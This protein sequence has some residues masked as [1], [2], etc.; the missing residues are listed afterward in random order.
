M[1]GRIILNRFHPA[2]TEEFLL[3]HPHA[4]GKQQNLSG[5]LVEVSVSAGVLPHLCYG[6]YAHEHVIEPYGV[7]LRTVTGKG[8]VA[9]PV[10]LVHDIVGVVSDALVNQPAQLLV[11]LLEDSAHRLDHRRAHRPCIVE[12]MWVNDAA[13]VR[14]NLPVLCIHLIIIR[15]HFGQQPVAA[16]HIL[17]VSLVAGSL[18][19]CQHTRVGHAPFVA[20][21]TESAPFQ[22]GVGVD[23]LHTGHFF[24]AVLVNQRGWCLRV[25][26]V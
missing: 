23:V 2:V 24:T 8:A 9:Q 25:N 19:C 26:I 10:F 4:L 12:G 16:V 18:I 11:F 6:G 3:R 17:A 1:E 5:S 20:C 15:S 13:H 22:L 7:L 14:V 21:Q